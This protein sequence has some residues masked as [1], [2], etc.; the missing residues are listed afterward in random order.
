MSTIQH[1]WATG[2]R[3]HKLSAIYYKNPKYWWLIA[4]YNQTPTEAHVKVG[5]LIYIPMPLERA[6]ASYGV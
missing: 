6:L 2:D 4:W 3:Y 1:V 5:E